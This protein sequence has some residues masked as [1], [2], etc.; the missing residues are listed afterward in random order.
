LVARMILVIALFALSVL[1]MG[2][3]ISTGLGQAAIADNL[4]WSLAAA[5]LDLGWDGTYDENATYSMRLQL[6]DH[7]YLLRDVKPSPGRGFV[8]LKVNVTVKTREEYYLTQTWVLENSTGGVVYPF[9]LPIPFTKPSP[10]KQ[11]YLIWYRSKHGEETPSTYLVFFELR[12]EEMPADLTIRNWRDGD[13]LLRIRLDNSLLQ[14]PAQGKYRN[15]S[16]LSGVRL[17][18]DVGDFDV[19]RDRE[20]S[21]VAVYLER[22]RQTGTVWIRM[23]KTTPGSG[24]PSG[25]SN[26]TVCKAPVDGNASWSMGEEGVTSIAFLEDSQGIYRIALASIQQAHPSNVSNLPNASEHLKNMS[27]WLLESGDRGRTW[28][29]PRRLPFQFLKGGDSYGFY[30]MSFVEDPCGTLWIVFNYLYYYRGNRLTLY[31]R[32]L[33]R[34]RTW[35]APERFR[36]DGLWLEYGGP[37]GSGLP[38]GYTGF[39]QSFFADELGRLRIVYIAKPYLGRGQVWQATS[40]DC[41]RSWKGPD[42][43][44]PPNYDQIPHVVMY[45]EKTSASAGQS[46]RLWLLWFST[47][48]ENC[49]LEYS[50][51]EGW[52]WH[53]FGFIEHP[54]P[55]RGRYALVQET[56][57]EGDDA[58][59]GLLLF[60]KDER[61][62]LLY[63]RIPEWRIPLSLIPLLI[64]ARRCRR[65]FYA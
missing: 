4:S 63:A 61:G 26:S 65:R 6:L 10:S 8:F 13:L 54:A 43:V 2:C 23:A 45:E 47:Y 21:I 15:L 35:T 3:P 59:V 22:E 36:I 58:G 30:D 62:D 50:C 34:G 18:K 42:Y 57:R 41:G 38:L 52:S 64:L 31:V 11:R 40:S 9:V 51:D 20:G 29:R 53:P 16:P 5:G 60:W 7:W 33:D 27:I 37:G 46:S 28:S 12:P 49:V 25:W 56:A 44:L 17:A 1:S 14:Y 32:S 55:S 19:K 48:E 39:Y 24:R